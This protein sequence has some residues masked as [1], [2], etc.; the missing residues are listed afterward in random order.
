MNII[1]NY[2]KTF[3]VFKVK[4]FIRTLKGFSQSYGLFRCTKKV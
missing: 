1:A 4:N 2:I 3:Q